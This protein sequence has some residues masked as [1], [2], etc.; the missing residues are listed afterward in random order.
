MKRMISLLL[1]MIALLAVPV[2]A[3]TAAVVD[4]AG[5]LDGDEMAALTEKADAI[6]T[7]H[8]FDAV[9]VTMDT[10]GGG[11]P[12]AWANDYY[13]ENGYGCGANDDGMLFLIVMDTRQWA[14]ST[15]GSG[16]DYFPDSGTDAMVDLILDDLSGGD[17]YDAFDGW[18][19]LCADTLSAGYP[20]KEGYGYD[21]GYAT[22][23]DYGYGHDY[24]YEYDYDY[25]YYGPEPNYALRFFVALIGGFLISMIPMGAM[26]RQI[27]NVSAR[28]GAEDYTRPGSMN[29][30]I[31]SDRFLYTNTR[32]V[33]RAE[34]SSGG[35][36]GGGG[37]RMSSGGGGRHGGGRGRF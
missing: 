33:R 8:Q 1:L 4:G 5:L 2:S 21:Y 10:I 29:M 37:H 20:E 19:T 24:G 3:A 11:D 7:E 27:R 36:R 23:Y 15:C 6:Y 14:V 25:A 13:D 18:L 28:S 35:H 31:H 16:R 9:I 12:W 26:K 30:T 22:E 32:R 34:N 17:Y